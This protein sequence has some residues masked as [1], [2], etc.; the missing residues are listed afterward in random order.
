MITIAYIVAAW[1]CAFGLVGLLISRG[2]ID[3]E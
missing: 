3:D 2:E 1:L